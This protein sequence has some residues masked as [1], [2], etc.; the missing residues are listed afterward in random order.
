M[1]RPL[2]EKIRPLN[3][4]RSGLRVSFA[5]GLEERRFFT[6][7]F[8]FLAVFLERLGGFAD[9]FAPA[10]RTAFFLLGFFLVTAFATPAVFFF[11]MQKSL[12]RKRSIPSVVHRP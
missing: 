6:T 5:A 1:R 12:S 3:V 2:V 11:A 4:D 8:T 7:A 9:I 10:L